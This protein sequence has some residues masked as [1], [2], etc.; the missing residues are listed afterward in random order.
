MIYVT[1][2][3]REVARTI[4]RT[5]VEEKLIACANIIDGMT[6]IYRWENKIEETMDCGRLVGIEQPRASAK[7]G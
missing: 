1:C 4:A 7:F 3:D 6:S 5:L 2:P